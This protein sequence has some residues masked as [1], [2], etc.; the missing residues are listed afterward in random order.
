M[1]KNRTSPFRA[2]RKGLQFV[3]PGAY[4]VPELHLSMF[5]EDVQQMGHFYRL[6][7]DEEPALIL[8]G[9]EEE[10]IK[11]GALC[12]SIA[13][14]PDQRPEESIA[15]AIENVVLHLAHYG[16]ALFEIASEPEGPG[17]SLAPVNP[18]YVWNLMFFYL[19]VAPRASWQG[20]EPRYAL[21]DKTAVWRIDMPHEL[22]G[23]RGFRRL[24]KELSAWSG[25]G[26]QFYQDDIRKLQL[27][28][29]FVFGDYRQAHQVQLYRVTRM[30]GWN[31]RDWSLDYITEYYQ[32]YRHITF[33]WAQAVLREHVVKEFNT[34]FHR[35]GITARIIMEGLS[36]AGDILKVREQMQA[37]VLDFAGAT[38]A[39]R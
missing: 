32:F 31:G 11:A 22:G 39:I 16:Q 3:S 38:K 1:K 2:G 14:Y 12:A 28:T 36:A 35:L 4:D 23:A 8:E 13:A 6:G 27:P 10:R 17:L 25:L 24:L 18:D 20:R 37:G 34:L 21:L 33:K 15:G 5:Q 26:P 9:T 19:Q 29:E 30:W 7:R